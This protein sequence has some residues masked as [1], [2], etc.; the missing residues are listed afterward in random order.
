M[1]KCVSK[2]GRIACVAAGLISLVLSA[3]APTRTTTEV[4]TT[5]QESEPEMTS[6]GEMEGEWEMVSPGEMQVR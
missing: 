1:L 4:R 5:R 2:P 3:C 6:P